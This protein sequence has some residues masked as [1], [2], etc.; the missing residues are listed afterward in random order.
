MKTISFAELE[1]FIDHK[2]DE[3]VMVVNKFGPHEHKVRE[4][5]EGWSVSEVIEHLV[6][7]EQQVV[8]TVEKMLRNHP[9][10]P[11]ESIL[12]KDV[13]II[14]LLHSKGLLKTK[15]EAPQ[16]VRPVE[17][18]PLEDGMERLKNVRQQL[19]SYLPE[20][21]ERETNSI[22]AHHPF[23]NLDLNVCQWIHFAAAHEWAH[24]HQL[25][26][27]RKATSFMS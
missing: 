14:P 3:L 15:K 22:I 6:L 25:N 4:H 24:I 8:N 16:F 20:L 1:A 10:Q 2:R 27:I 11:S 23:L 17:H 21:S 12:E 5:T 9:H 7:V 19:K 18:V 26:R 13:D